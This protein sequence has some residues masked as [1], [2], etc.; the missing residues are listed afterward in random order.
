MPKIYCISRVLVVDWK[1][2][3]AGQAP[4]ILHEGEVI[5]AEGASPETYTYHALREY[6]KTLPNE[7][8]R[9]RL[10]ARVK[11]RLITVEKGPAVR[12]SR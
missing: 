4:E 1:E 5:V 10:D 11:Q 6:G 3:A 12:V 9:D 2:D 8:A 7:A